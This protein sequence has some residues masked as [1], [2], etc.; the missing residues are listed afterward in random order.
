MH[1]LPRFF[2]VPKVCLVLAL[3]GGFIAMFC[4]NTPQVVTFNQQ[5]L[6]G[7]FVAQ[8]SAHTLTKEALR[9]KTDRFSLALKTSLCAY[10][11]SHRVLVLNSSDVLAGEHDI[12]PRIEQ[13]IARLMRRSS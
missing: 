6:M 1:R 13:D 11:K 12:T 3:V 10:A 8:L 5:Q 4:T 9:E 2:N 7:R